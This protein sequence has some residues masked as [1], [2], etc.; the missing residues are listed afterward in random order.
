M[1]KIVKTTDF[2]GKYAITQNQFNTTKLQAFIDKYELL[3]IYDLLG[4]TLGNLFYNDIAVSTF[5]PPV[6]A[7]Y[8]TLF[9]AIYSDSD[10]FCGQIRSEGV[11]E[12]L[13]G[14]IYWEFVKAQKAK[15][16]I[17]GTVVGQNE[18]SRETDWNETEIYNNYNQAVMTYRSIQRYISENPSD[19]TEYKGLNKQYNNWF[20]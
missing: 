18:V 13:K 2:T 19:Y 11:K 15:N 5:L 8:A 10:N 7:K 12:M 14:F 17:T 9:N 4:V 1:G 16:T 6:T 3:Y 20:I